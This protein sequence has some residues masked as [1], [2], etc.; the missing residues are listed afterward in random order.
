MKTSTIKVTVNIHGNPYPVAC[1]E[2]DEAQL[3][4]IVKYVDKKVSEIAKNAANAGETR[5]LALA[6]MTIAAEL[7]EAK[8]TQKTVKNSNEDVMIAA[9]EHLSQRVASIASR[10]G[11]G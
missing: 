10:I 5:I 4:E 2:G 7:M 1:G 9:V 6:C 8:R 3:K 11:A